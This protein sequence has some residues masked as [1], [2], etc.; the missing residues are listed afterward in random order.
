MA[1]LIRDLHDDDLDGILQ[2]WELVRSTGPAPVYSLAEVIASCQKDHA[3]VAVE[4]GRVVGAAV[5]RAAHAQGWIVFFAV[6]R[7]HV[8]TDIGS[9]LLSALERRMLPLGLAKLSVLLA[10]GDDLVDGFESAGFEPRQSLRYLERVIP[11]QRQELGVLQELGGRLLRRDLWG[12][13]A[14]MRTEKALLEQRLVLPLAQPDLAAEFGVVPPRA[15]MLFGPPGTGKTTFA[16][17]VASRLGWPF[18]EVFPSRLAADERGLPAALRDTFLKVAELEHAVLFMDE[19]EEVASRRRG[20]PPSAMQGVTN[21][22][23]KLIPEFRDQPGRLLICA[24]N[25]IRA[26]D[27]AFLRHGRFD[28]VIPIGLPDE[29][30]RRAIWERYIPGSVI[31]SIDLSRLVERSDGLTPAD[32]EYAARAASQSALERALRDPDPAVG[33]LVTEDY[34]LALRGTRATVS[35]ETAAEFFQDIEVLARL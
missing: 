14:G 10:E 24:T 22:L 8:E 19:V 35:A 29:D 27:G 17:A 30:A 34:L 15:V 18:V 2:L 13:V 32:I 33:T 20:D 3:V 28:Y 6:D 25:F 4:A 21:E 1:I 12:E 16:R 23:L 9:R 5:G 11:V 31:G 7:S 26:L